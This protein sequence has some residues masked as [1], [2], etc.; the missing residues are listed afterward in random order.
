MMKKIIS[1]TL[2]V[3]VLVT[4]FSGVS[5]AAELHPDTPSIYFKDTIPEAIALG[6]VQKEIQNDYRK[7]ITRAEFAKLFV[8][9]LFTWQKNNMPAESKEWFGVRAITKKDVL[10][11]VTALDYSFTDVTDDDIKIAYILGL[12]NGTGKTTFTPDKPITRQEGATM[13][14][15]Y[16]HNRMMPNY[17]RLESIITDINKCAPFA[18]DSVL[19][20]WN[21][22]FFEGTSGNRLDDNPKVTM[23]P[24]GHF[25][26][27]QAITIAL[28][29][30]KNDNQYFSGILI[31]GKTALHGDALKV[32]WTITKD[33]ITAVKFKNGMTINYKDDPFYHDWTNYNTPAKDYPHAT[34][35][36]KIAAY[37]DPSSLFYGY[38]TEEMVKASCKNENAIFDLGYAEYEMHNKD[39]IYQYRFK[40]N[41]IY[42][43]ST[44]GGAAQLPIVKTR[45][46]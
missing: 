23:T 45:I 25:T 28:R 4:L 21:A 35:E 5:F 30:Y 17:V 12:T 36:Q 7:P 16:F 9:A 40:N 20:A 8:N 44:Y 24:E 15:N 3:A 22:K 1:L 2:L 33:T 31:R 14:V 41:G 18:R 32:E 26:R 46:K 6:F 34:S 19:A 13:L 10:E 37:N 39:Y 11:N 27:E 38:A 42:N 43:E 29:I